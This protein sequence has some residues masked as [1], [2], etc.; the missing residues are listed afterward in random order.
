MTWYNDQDANQVWSKVVV[1]EEFNSYPHIVHGGIVAALLDETVGRA[2]L[3]DGNI[4]RLM[5]TAKLD[6]RYRKPTPAGKELMVV[7]WVLRENGNR[8][9][10]AGEIR[11]AD[12]TVTAECKALIV[13]PPIDYLQNFNWS[14]DTNDWYVDEE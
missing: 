5:V 12:G 1:P 4:E 3:L 2:V 13:R 6:I 7:G 8:A 11:L 14:A 9:R 10:V